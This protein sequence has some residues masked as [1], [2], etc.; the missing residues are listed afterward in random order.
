MSIPRAETGNMRFG[1]DWTGVFVRGDT[2]FAMATYLNRVVSQNRQGIIPNP[3]LL[4]QLEGFTKALLACQHKGQ[5]FP[6][7]QL[8]V[9]VPGPPIPEDEDDDL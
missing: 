1:D 6:E 5:E 3:I 2:A 4:M 9:L 8:A 7:A